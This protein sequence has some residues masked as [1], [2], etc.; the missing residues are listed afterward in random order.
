VFF[1]VKFCVSVAIT[2]FFNRIVQS[3][4]FAYPELRFIGLFGNQF[5]P[6]SG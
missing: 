2:M 1:S 3:W 4:P 6:Q 5:V